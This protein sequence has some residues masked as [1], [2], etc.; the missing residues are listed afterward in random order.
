MM[1]TARAVTTLLIFGLL[2]AA[3]MAQTGPADP[4]IIATAS[5]A[6]INV[7]GRKLEGHMIATVTVGVGGRV[8]DVKI[9]ENTADPEFEPQL[10]KVFESAQFRPAIGDNG[11]PV[12]STLDM[13]IELRES[14]ANQPK[15]LALNPP[16]DATER[17]VARIKKMRCADFV[18]EWELLRDA[19]SDPAAEFMP[20]IATNTYAQMRADA[21]DYVGAKVWKA[22]PKALKQAAK[23]CED[24]PNAPFWD[25]TFKAILDE[26]IPK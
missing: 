20:R 5:T 3:A 24:T 9:K 16:A 18:W 14:T 12:E 2:P 8:R 10:V 6:K 26:E 1:P 19:A 15:P 22:S 4:E 11:L 21:G 25:S 17:E 13:I 7:G 23:Q